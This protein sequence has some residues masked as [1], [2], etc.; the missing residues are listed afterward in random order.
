MDL[1][2][3]FSLLYPSL[4]A[5]ILPAQT[6]SAQEAVPLWSFSPALSHQ[7]LVVAANWLDL[8]GWS[9]DVMS[10]VPV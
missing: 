6:R 3:R 10:V 1:L 9:H 4:A 2:V 8:V 7:W 5:L